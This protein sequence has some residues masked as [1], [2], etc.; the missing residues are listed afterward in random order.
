MDKREI[1]AG[2]SDLATEIL[3]YMARNP[4]ASDTLEGIVEWW[5]LEH[6]IRSRTALVQ[7][8]LGELV[9]RRLMILFYLLV[10]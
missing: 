3:S 7:A 2:C 10:L 6:R 4:K 8:A 1:T 9:E 5:L